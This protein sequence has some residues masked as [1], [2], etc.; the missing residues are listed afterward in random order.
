VA[1]GV[2]SLSLDIVPFLMA[3]VNLF[4]GGRQGKKRPS[5]KKKMAISDASLD[6]LEE[7]M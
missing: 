6:F 4:S 7:K 2:T 5:G 3:N 1:H